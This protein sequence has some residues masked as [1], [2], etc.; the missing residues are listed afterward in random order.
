MP[1]EIIDMY[2]A[3][4]VGNM[5]CALGVSEYW[6][7]EPDNESKEQMSGMVNNMYDSG[8]R[9]LG[10][11]NRTPIL[12]TAS[13]DCCYYNILD[14]GASWMSRNPQPGETSNDYATVS[15]YGGVVQ[16]VPI[17]QNTGEFLADGAEITPMGVSAEAGHCTC[18]LAGEREPFFGPM[19][20]DDKTKI[21]LICQKAGL[22]RLSVSN[23]VP[24]LD[25]ETAEKSEMTSSRNAVEDGKNAQTRLTTISLRKTDRLKRRLSP[26]R[27]PKPA[28]IVLP[29]VFIPSMMSRINTRK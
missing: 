7:G 9:K 16:K 14:S 25:G 3:C 6:F 19:S 22:K 20:D 29:N 4:E 27:Q 15:G 12:G 13:V 11:Q 17:A 2:G 26:T 18:W 10:V 5:V 28:N 23:N 8:V 24:I 1:R 21:R